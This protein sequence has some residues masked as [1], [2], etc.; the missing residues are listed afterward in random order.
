[1][2]DVNGNNSMTNYD[3]DKGVGQDRTEN[4]TIRRKKKKN[5]TRNDIIK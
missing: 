1:M 3:Y 2:F 4:V 5:W